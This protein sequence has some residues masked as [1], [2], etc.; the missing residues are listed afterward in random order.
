MERFD[1]QA[2]TEGQRVCWEDVVVPPE[3]L[4]LIRC[5]LIA[6]FSDTEIV[7]FR[8]GHPKACYKGEMW[9]TPYTPG[10]VAIYDIKK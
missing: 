5:P 3:S 8:F 6:P 9:N 4:K 7:F 2:H 1:A 10:G